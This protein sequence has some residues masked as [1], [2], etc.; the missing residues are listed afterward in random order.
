MKG[1]HLA[2]VGCGDLG[3]RLAALVAEESVCVTG[4]RRDPS[5]LP[6]GIEGVVAD[7]TDPAS[8][9]VLEGLAPD[10]LLLTLKP[11]GRDPVGYRAGF[12]QATDAVLKG[13]GRH[14]PRGVLMVSSTRVY[15]EDGGGRVDESGPLNMDDPAALSIIRAEQRLMSSKAGS[16][17]AVC[18]VRG[19]GLYSGESPRLLQRV[20]AGEISPMTPVHYTNRIHR[21]DLAGLLVHLLRAR[22]AGGDWP[23][24]INAVDDAS[25]SR[26]EV[27]RWLLQEL[28]CDVLLETTQSPGQ[29]QGKRCSNR[30][31]H[32]CGYQLRY[33][34][35]RHGYQAAIAAW[36]TAQ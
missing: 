27:E 17:P 35:Y 6:P 3:E 5:R 4:L 2:I 29:A 36:R 34:D 20:A 1:V 26:Q 8:L 22:E 31:L 23:P 9:K 19:G 24:V 32:A 7:Y 21:D 16:V 12:E 25:V 10:Y 28:G 18:I 14:R 13:L 33:P 15:A 30:I 11:V